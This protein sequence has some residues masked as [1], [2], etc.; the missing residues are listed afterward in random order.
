MQLLTAQQA[1]NVQLQVQTK[2]NQAVQIAHMDAL[3]S[4]A[5]L[6]QQRNFDHIFGSI[7]IYDGTNKE[8]YSKW[9][10]TLEAACLQS[11]RNCTDVLGKAG[12]IVWT[13]LMGLPV[14][15]LWSSMWQELKRCFSNL[16][17]AAHTAMSLNKITEKLNKSLFIY[18]FEA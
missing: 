9:V 5:K 12:D 17:K 14:N 3:K 7:P 11:G 18:V 4:L 16:L 13:C 1:A 8:G 10:E 6:T 15:L 2:Q